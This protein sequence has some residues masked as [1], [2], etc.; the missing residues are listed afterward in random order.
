V[1][2]DP[3]AGDPGFD[4]IT[5]QFAAGYLP[6]LKVSEFISQEDME[7]FDEAGRQL[8]QGAP[9][10]FYQQ[11]IRLFSALV[12]D[13]LFSSNVTIFDVTEK[14]GRCP[15]RVVAAFQFESGNEHEIEQDAPPDTDK[16][17]R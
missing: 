16:P 14:S 17:C 15:C 1:Y 11:E 9:P 12:S 3:C 8:M 4:F 6:K 7:L 10:S 5:P 13:D 2:L